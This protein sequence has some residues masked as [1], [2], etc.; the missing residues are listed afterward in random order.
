MAGELPQSPVAPDSGR[1]K[2]V[3]RGVGEG[4]ELLT[5]WGWVDF[6]VLYEVGVSGGTVNDLLVLRPSLLEGFV[7][8]VRHLSVGVESRWGVAPVEGLEYG[9]Y[10]TGFVG[11]RQGVPLMEVLGDG[12][13]QARLSAPLFGDAL[14][15]KG[16]GRG[17]AGFGVRFDDWE[18]WVTGGGFPRVA[19]VNPVSGDVFFVKPLHFIWS[20][21]SGKLLR[22][23]MTGVDLLSTLFTDY[24][25]RPKYGRFW[26]FVLGDDM[27][28]AGQVRTGTESINYQLLNKV[29]LN[30]SGIPGVS[31]G[32]IRKPS[33]GWQGFQFEGRAAGLVDLYGWWYPAEY[34]GVEMRLPAVGGAAGIGVGVDGLVD[35]VLGLSSMLRV[36]VDSPI[37]VFPKKHLSRVR[38]WDQYK[39]AGS[40]A[41]R[42]SVNVFGLVVAPY[43]NFVVRRGKQGIG[44]RAKWLGGAVV[45]GDALDK[46]ELKV[47][48]RKGVISGG[49]Y[50]I[51]R[52]DYKTLRAS[53]IRKQSEIAGAEFGDFDEDDT[54]D[55]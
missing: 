34:L 54:N 16:N 11:V 51:L 17:V 47:A 41:V 50:S 44:S 6:D 22:L 19:S 25:V 28:R 26:K 30:P 38:V 53:S 48:G 33:T 42:S 31:E 4:F 43:H 3:Q 12:R 46:S 1:W 7:A 55:D 14:P 18:R 29:M 2:P 40:D 36:N 37:T 8:S 52:P 49:S 15:F 39:V 20:N 23:K 9:L 10:D 35:S 5:E 13:V 27:V 45:L 21:Y 32:F 24:W